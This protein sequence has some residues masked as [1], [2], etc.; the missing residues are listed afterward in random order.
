MSD[1]EKIGKYFVTIIGKASEL[2]FNGE[3]IKDIID[4]KGMHELQ[5]E[6]GNGM[7]YEFSALAMMLL[8]DNPTAK[9]C[10]GYYQSKDGDFETPHSWVEFL[11][12][13]M[14]VFV[15]DFAWMYPG[16][17]S[18]SDYSKRAESEGNLTTKWVCSYDDFWGYAPSKKI[19]EKMQKK[20]TSFV[21]S[22]LI[23][24]GIP[25]LGFDFL[26]SSPAK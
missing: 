14:G 3:T 21:L 9:I 1:E 6:T 15:A 24:Y 19:Y 16:F 2:Y 25:E 11:V 4:K 10:R 20:D 7:C 22:D 13:E 18:L 23:V 26:L 17:C 5:E 8:K 12:P